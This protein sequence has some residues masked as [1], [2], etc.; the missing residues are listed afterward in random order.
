MKLSEPVTGIEHYKAI[1]NTLIARFGDEHPIDKVSLEAHRLWYW[2][3]AKFPEHYHAFSVEGEPFDVASVEAPPEA[4]LVERTRT[5]DDNLVDDSEENRERVRAAGR[6]LTGG[7]KIHPGD[8]QHGAL[9]KFV[10]LCWV[11]GLSEAAALDETLL[12]SCE[13]DAKDVEPDE[14][15][16]PLAAAR[17]SPASSATSTRSRRRKPSRASTWC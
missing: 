2:R 3:S 4:P 9:V 13:E 1:I 8:G 5:Y 6:R 17:R 14:E 16:S 7:K 11:H 12:F 10:K 15:G